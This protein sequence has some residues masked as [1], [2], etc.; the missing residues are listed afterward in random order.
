MVR[1]KLIVDDVTWLFYSEV[2]AVACWGWETDTEDEEEDGEDILNHDAYH[3]RIS[4]W[5]KFAFEPTPYMEQ[6]I[7]VSLRFIDWFKFP[8]FLSLLESDQISRKYQNELL[9]VIITI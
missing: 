2:W 7:G 1:Q 4:M 9:S 3:L 6:L 5:C 8:K